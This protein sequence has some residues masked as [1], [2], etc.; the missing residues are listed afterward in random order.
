MTEPVRP[1]G[2]NNI[3][4]LQPVIRITYPKVI[5]IVQSDCVDA[6]GIAGQGRHTGGCKKKQNKKNKKLPDGLLAI[7]DSKFVLQ[8][9][10]TEEQSHYEM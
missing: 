1:G 7:V 3:Q 4:I 2:M 8:R 6:M 10:Q 9:L 5:N